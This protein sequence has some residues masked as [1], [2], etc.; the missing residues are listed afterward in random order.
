M[1]TVKAFIR[2]VSKKKD[3][4]NV[5]FRYSNGRK[6]QIFHKSEIIIDPSIFDEKKECVKA[7]IIINSEIRKSID[8]SI[9]QRKELIMTTCLGVDDIV[10]TSEWLEKSI[11]EVLHPEKYAKPQQ[12]FFDVFEEF[13]LKRPL[14][15]ARTKNF[16]VI[17]RALKRFELYTQKMNRKE[18]NY[19]LSFENISSDTLERFTKFLRN[20][21]KL[22]EDQPEIHKEFPEYHNPKP[23]GQ[24]TINSIM[25]KLSTLFSWANYNE[26]TTNNP[27]DKYV[28][29]NS[30]YGTPYYITIEERNN[31]YETDLSYI[32]RL[33]RQRDIFIFHCMI[34]C[35]ISD[36]YRLKKQ[37]VIGNAIE[38]I[39]RKTKNDS[40]KTVRVPLNNTAKEIID[41]YAQLDGENLLPFISDQKYNKAIKEIFTIAGLT[42]NV[43][44]LDPLTRVNAIRPLN[45]IASSH[46]ARR[47][48]IGNLYKQVKDPNLVGALSGHSEGSKAFARYRDID[49]DMK[50]DLVK[51]LE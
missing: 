27:F 24:N 30:V 48:F 47:T 6:I 26:K 35:R 41:K 2:T 25:N 45:E 12:S 46:L 18:A 50:I 37:N 28:I 15:E 40:P 19:T 17:Y 10:L 39:A 42:R 32:P 43:T 7:K 49:E 4:A 31:L 14:S 11:D 29:E 38:Y 36:L 51:M 20:E 5:R 34:G 13:L 8:R 3:T 22:L 9:S 23:R 1:P 44:I 16:R 21:Y 33:E